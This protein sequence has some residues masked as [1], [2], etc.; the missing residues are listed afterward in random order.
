MFHAGISACERPIL[1]LLLSDGGMLAYQA[2]QPPHHPLA[3]RRLP[4]DWTT[5]PTPPSARPAALPH[6]NAVQPTQRMQVCWRHARNLLTLNP[7]FTRGGSVVTGGQGSDM[8]THS[9]ACCLADAMPAAC[10]ACLH[11]CISS[12]AS[13]RA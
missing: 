9:V 1:L 12:C 8:D 4:L 5:H 3:F 6:P 2:F 10:I 7:D 13:S 11:L